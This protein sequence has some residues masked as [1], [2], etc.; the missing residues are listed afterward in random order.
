[1]T[2]QPDQSICELDPMTIY[3]FVSNYTNELEQVHAEDPKPIFD[4]DELCA[5]V[6]LYSLY[7]ITHAPVTRTVYTA[8]SDN[9]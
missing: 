2:E 3:G 1:M 6:I 8:P 4:P 9:L 5:L 7:H